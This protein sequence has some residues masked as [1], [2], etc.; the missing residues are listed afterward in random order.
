LVPAGAFFQANGGETSWPSPEYFLG[1]AW[2]FSKA[3][4]VTAMTEL[5]VFMGLSPVEERALAEDFAA[6]WEVQD[7]KVAAATISAADESSRFDLAMAN[8]DPPS[9]L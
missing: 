3:L 4:L 9:V 2:P 5:E 8:I 7:A 1:I 6:S